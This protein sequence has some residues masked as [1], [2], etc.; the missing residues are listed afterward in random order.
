M[1]KT[2]DFFKQTH[3]PNKYTKD[4]QKIKYEQNNTQRMYQQITQCGVRKNYEQ[5]K[6]YAKNYHKSS[7]QDVQKVSDHTIHKYN[8]RE[9][10]YL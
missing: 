10:K 6:Q 5:I 8:K 2:P 1:L 7:Q 4:E 3:W 9:K